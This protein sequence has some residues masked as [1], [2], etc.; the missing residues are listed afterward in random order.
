MPDL[1][2]TDV[3]AI[4]LRLP[5]VRG[6]TDSSQDS[7]VVRVTTDAGIIGY[8]EVDSSPVV[9]KAV[10]EAPTS[11]LLARGLREVLV[12]QNPLETDRLW[13]T[14]YQ[15]TLYF[16]REGAVIQAMAGVDLALW[17]IKGQALGQPVW[18]LLGG[19]YR[20]TLRAYASHMFDFEPK[21]TARR[22][23]EAASA[24][25]TA[26]KFGWEPMG[27]DPELDEALVRGIREAV[28]SDVDVCIDAGLAWD[29]K[30]AIQRCQLF[31][32]YNI[33]WLEEPLHPDDLR[34]YRKLASAVSTRIAAG[35]EECTPAGFLRL[36][37]EGNIDVVQIDLT[38]VGF[39]QAM[40]VAALAQQRGVQCCNHNFTTD[41]NV[42]ASL[43]F[44]AAV[45]NALMLEY[46]VEPSP[47]RTGI[48]RNPIEV[49]DGY[50]A[51][52]E[53]PGLGIE[54]DLDR[55]AQ[56]VQK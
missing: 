12:G 38:R 7:L 54:V 43:H 52:P 30:T 48:T 10:I 4:H 8:G 49:V 1:K 3:E 36:M 25:F 35:E 47:L 6:R 28:G 11:H 31:Q 23:A 37:D 32:P 19:A 18:A 24:G 51:V 34:G 26:V 15:S 45:P 40:R 42:A 17:D 13:D 16:G 56:F 14:M 46:C 41:I 53:A 21:I 20:K 39:T 29:A 33:F 5:E 9:V 22:A 50:A 55:V 27:P 44:L 2:I